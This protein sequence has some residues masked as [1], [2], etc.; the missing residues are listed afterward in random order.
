MSQ[1]EALYAAMPV[2]LPV[3]FSSCTREGGTDVV[4]VWLIPISRSEAQYAGTHGWH[5]F[6]DRLAGTDADLT[7][8][9]RAPSF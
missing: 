5:A 8:V 4:F 9:D 7:D 3:E 6:E 2:Y 1:L